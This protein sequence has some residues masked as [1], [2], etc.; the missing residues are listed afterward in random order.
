VQDNGLIEEVSPSIVTDEINNLLTMIPSRL[1]IEN[2]V[3]SLNKDGA[4]DLMALEPFLIKHIGKLS[5]MMSLMMYWSS[6]IPIGS[7]QALMLIQWY[8]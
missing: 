3:F 1:K 5:K 4:P 7:C 8:H 2:A 6:L